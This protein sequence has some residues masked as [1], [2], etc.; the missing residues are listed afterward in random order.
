MDNKLKL[1]RHESFSIREGWLT[2]GLKNIK[3]NNKV[4]SDEKATDILGIGSNM[5]KSL[6]YWMLATK[7][8]EEKNK[9]MCLTDFGELIYKY[10]LY[11]EYSFSW[12]LIHLNLV[13]NTEDAYVYNLFFNLCRNREFSKKDIFER[14]TDFLNSKKIEYNDK[15]LQDEISII[16]RTYTIDEKID[17]PENNFI[18]PLSELNMIKKIGKD[19]YS[20]IKP[21]YKELHYLVVFY[22]IEQ[23]LTERE[24]ISI[25]ELSESTNGPCNLLNLDKS[26]LNDYL[27]DLKKNKYIIINRTAGLNMIYINNKLTIEEIITEYFDGGKQ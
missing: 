15:M 24:S 26:L 12:W 16:V 8:A 27:D 1:K 19:Q 2:K 9:G 7:L 5:V 11:L 25:E 13:L 3:E 21:N 4:F 23:L 6:K 18:C 14:I 10:D 22:L 20:K 17:N